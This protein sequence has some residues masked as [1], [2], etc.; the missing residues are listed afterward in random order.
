MIWYEEEV[1]RI[2]QE[3][4]KLSYQPKTIFYG[5]SSIRLWK[6]LYKD[7]EDFYPVN[8][9]FGGSTLAA[10][11]WYFDRIIRG[12]EP[13][14]LIVYAG[15]NDLGDGRNP[16]EVFIFFQQLLANIQRSFPDIA[17]TFI[18]VKPSIARRNLKNQICYTNQLIRK[19]IEKSNR[20]YYFLNVYDKMVD[21]SGNPIGDLYDR[22]GLHMSSKGYALW[23]DLLL[24]HISSKVESGLIQV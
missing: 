10:C 24:T 18:S 19:Y 8:L 4:N 5:S 17:V 12:Y 15:D 1:K 7:F 22:D 20:D 21:P 23:K 9:G 13:D 16:E 14:H 2:E 6:D 3:K 11:V